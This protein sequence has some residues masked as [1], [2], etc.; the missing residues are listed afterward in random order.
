L[1]C[2]VGR[3]LDSKRAFGPLGKRII[4]AQKAW[5]DQGNLINLCMALCMRAD[6]SR[7]RYFLNPDH[8]K[9]LDDAARWLNF[10]IH[11][12]DQCQNQDEL[13]FLLMHHNCVYGKFRI[14]IDQGAKADKLRDEIELLRNLGKDIDLPKASFLTACYETEWSI[15][16]GETEQAEQQLTHARKLVPQI[17]INPFFLRGNILRL[18]T[19][20]AHKQGRFDERDAYFHDYVTLFKQEPTTHGY[21]DLGALRQLCGNLP[22]RCMLQKRPRLYVTLMF[23]FLQEHLIRF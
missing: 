1:D 4:N 17:G 2:S 12:L 7:A 10:A 20:L 21:H 14:K 9:H 11:V 18:Q 16:A 22:E 5:Q 8:Q 6:F 13:I 19:A 23:S 15:L 3:L